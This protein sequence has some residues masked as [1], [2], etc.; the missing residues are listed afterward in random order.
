MCTSLC[1]V[2]EVV[3]ECGVGTILCTVHEVVT[4]CGV[5]RCI[6]TYVLF[7]VLYMR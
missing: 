4:E 2:H 1:T 6:R 7:C 5:S 3:M